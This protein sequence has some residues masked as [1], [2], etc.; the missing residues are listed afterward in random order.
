MAITKKDTVIQN[1]IAFLLNNVAPPFASL[2]LCDFKNLLNAVSEWSC[3]NQM[4]NSIYADKWY[5]L[6]EIRHKWVY[7]RRNSHIM[8]YH[9]LLHCSILSSVFQNLV[10]L[11]VN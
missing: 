6:Q 10:D 4:Q 5:H 11:E 1:V 9:K 2:L 8:A 7:K 3:E